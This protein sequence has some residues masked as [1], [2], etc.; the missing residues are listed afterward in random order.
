ML[1][2]LIFVVITLKTTPQSH[3][4]GHKDYRGRFIKHSARFDVLLM[5]DSVTQPCSLIYKRQLSFIFAL[6]EA[7]LHVS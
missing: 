4:W 6:K 7:L 1:Y 3:T 2:I 5:A